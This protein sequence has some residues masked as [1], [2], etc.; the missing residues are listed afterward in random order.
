VV[1]GIRGEY[2]H[3]YSGILKAVALEIKSSGTL[4]PELFLRIW[5][6]KGAMRVIRHVRM[7]EYASRYAPAIGRA[8]KEPPARKLLVLLS[9]RGISKS[10]RSNQAGVPKPDAPAN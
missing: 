1:P 9:L 8:V 7:A 2:E 5:K 4:S 3:N 6:W 10:D